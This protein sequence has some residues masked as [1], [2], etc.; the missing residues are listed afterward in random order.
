MARKPQ[1]GRILASRAFPN[2]ADAEEFATAYKA[3]YREA[4]ISIK[5]DINRTDDSQWKATVYAKVD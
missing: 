4:D 5:Y 1:Y 3:Q 2:R